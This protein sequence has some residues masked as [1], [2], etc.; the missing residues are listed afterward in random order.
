MAR[1]AVPRCFGALQLFKCLDWV[2]V[3]F[4]RFEGGGILMTCSCLAS[5]KAQERSASRVCVCV[6]VSLS[7]VLKEFLQ[8]R[9]HTD[10]YPHPLHPTPPPR[11][12]PSQTF[13]PSISNGTCPSDTVKTSRDHRNPRAEKQ[14]TTLVSSDGRFRVHH[15]ILW[16]KKHNIYN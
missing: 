4:R 2:A 11:V 14:R 16:K 5:Q 9:E 10:R 12:S 6:C 7:A 1:A 15:F 3:L 13:L 8:R